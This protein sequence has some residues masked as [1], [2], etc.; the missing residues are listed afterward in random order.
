[1]SDQHPINDQ[2]D[3]G[4]S[5]DSASLQLFVSITPTSSGLIASSI[6]GLQARFHL[7]A[8]TDLYALSLLLEWLRYTER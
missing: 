2:H 1:M 6:E 4:A 7:G 5:E 8:A 3:T